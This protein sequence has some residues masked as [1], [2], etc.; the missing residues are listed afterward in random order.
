MVK[1]TKE[2]A[3]LYHSQGKPGKIEVVPTKP[4]ST[5]TDLSLAYSPGVA[6]PCL[7]IEKNPNDAY[8]YTAKGNLVA[9]ISNGTAVLG[10]GDIGAMAGKP[11]MEGKGLLFKIYGGIDVF[12]IEV[13][14]K[15][16]DKFIEAVKAIA[17]TFGGINLEDIKA[18]ECFEIERRLKEELDIPVMHDD[19]H[20]T[21]IISSAGLINAL[22]VAGKKIEDVKIVVNGA[23]AA[24]ISCTKLYEALGE[25]L[26][27][28][29]LATYSIFKKKTVIHSPG[30]LSCNFL[31]FY[32]IMRC[33]L[34]RFREPD[35]PLICNLSRGQFYSIFVIL[36]GI[37]LKFYVKKHPISQNRCIFKSRT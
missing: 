24:A 31:I 18:P 7:E 5:Q 36:V 16:P 26:L 8:K 6:E 1:I 15:D 28:F 35:A 25:G 19:Q 2:A 13:N 21:A 10:L 17:P 22:E 37:L 23:G 9:V 30:K 14:E 34:E 12:D 32:G 11:V 27:I 20:G 29:I 33:F 3:L 4:Y